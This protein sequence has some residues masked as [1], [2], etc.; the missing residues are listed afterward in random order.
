MLSRR[1][2]KNQ[3]ETIAVLQAGLYCLSFCD[4]LSDCDGSSGNK[5]LIGNFSVFKPVLL[6]KTGIYIKIYKNIC[7][8]FA[9]I[10]SV[11]FI[12]AFI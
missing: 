9:M 7:D 3:N 8:L 12:I 6:T 4:D 11:Q 10:L 5:I 1:R 2:G